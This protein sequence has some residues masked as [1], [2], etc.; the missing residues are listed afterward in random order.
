MF[1]HN[2]CTHSVLLHNMI[3]ISTTFSQQSSLSFFLS[4]FEMSVSQLFSQL[5]FLPLANINLKS[6]K[7]HLKV[8]KQST[9][10][11]FIVFTLIN[12]PHV[13]LLLQTPSSLSNSHRCE[14]LCSTVTFKIFTRYCTSLFM[15]YA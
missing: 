15:F 11:Y 9:F 6:K 13:A 3:I 1:T 5:F 4:F 12:W 2:Y 8:Q 10:E 7:V 14:C